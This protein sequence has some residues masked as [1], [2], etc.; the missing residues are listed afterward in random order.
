MLRKRPSDGKRHENWDYLWAFCTWKILCFYDSVSGRLK[1]RLMFIHIRHNITIQWIGLL[2]Y[3]SSLINVLESFPSLN[4][5]NLRPRRW[6]STT[7]ESFLEISLLAAFFDDHRLLLNPPTDVYL[8]FNFG[9]NVFLI[10]RTSR[11]KRWC[12]FSFPA[13]LR[14]KEFLISS[15][16]SFAFDYFLLCFAF[17]FCLLN[18]QFLSQHMCA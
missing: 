12:S 1:R 10:S 3:Q 2:S 5:A 9:K 16:S 18:Q 8:K 7:V 4:T 17:H 6:S 13:K 11:A 14:R 15:F